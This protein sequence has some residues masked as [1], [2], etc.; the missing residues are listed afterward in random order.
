MTAEQLKNAG[1]KRF[2]GVLELFRCK[3]LSLIAKKPCTLFLLSSPDSRNK[4]EV[5]RCH[6]PKNSVNALFLAVEFSISQQWFRKT[7]CSVGI[8]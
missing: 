4:Q 8:I 6:E 2:L 1:A 5:N 3:V 7:I